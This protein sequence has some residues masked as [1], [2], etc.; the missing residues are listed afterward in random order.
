MTTTTIDPLATGIACS[1]ETE[2]ELLFFTWKV[3]VQNLAASKATIVDASGLLTLVLDD[4][5]WNT[6]SVNQLVGIGG[7]VE[8]APRPVEPAHVPI[9]AGMTNDQIS[10]AKY[11]ND[12]HLIWHEARSALKNE[13]IRSLGTTLASTI[14]PPPIS[15]GVHYDHCATNRS[16]C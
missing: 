5:E 15:H 14:G 11:T 13:I 6:H 9:T 16:G 7:A 4:R 12:R 2:P 3:Q 1:L 8:I 10:V